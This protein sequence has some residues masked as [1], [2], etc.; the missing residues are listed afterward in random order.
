MKKHHYRIFYSQQESNDFACNDQIE[1]LIRDNYIDLKIAHLFPARDLFKEGIQ[2]IKGSKNFLDAFETVDCEKMDLM[3]PL[4]DIQFIKF[5]DTNEIVLNFIGKEYG[6]G[7]LTT[8]GTYDFTNKFL[9]EN[10]KMRKFARYCLENEFNDILYKNI[11][12]LMK[13]LPDQTK[14]YRF[15]KVNDKWFL[16]A[17]TSNKYNNYD[18][19][20]AI[21][22]TF[23]AVDNYAELN[24]LQLIVGD[25]Y[26][27]D[28]ELR[29]KIY[30]L[31]EYEI[32]NDVTVQFGFFTSNNELTEGT[33]SLEF[34]YVVRNKKEQTF[35]GLSNYIFN[36]THTVSIEKLEK[37][38]KLTKNI[39]DYKEE[40]LNYITQVYEEE[41][42][43]NQ[44]FNIFKT[45]T[46]AKYKVNAETRSK[47]EQIKEESIGNTMNLIELFNRLEDI[48]T[49]V[50]EKVYLE[51]IYHEVL[52]D[53]N[54]SIKQKINN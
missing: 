19:H 49:D 9:D 14:Q 46:S 39:N 45:I 38:F 5:D 48:T 26:L 22:T 15:L 51:R 8:V 23:V 37:Q 35:R 33:F 54:N 10:F 31:Q 36:L 41:L 18:N 42:S 52:V 25:S 40:I 3:E 7:G 24:N 6:A 16:R 21:Y 4:K 44:I 28:S 1:L 20:L 2:Y 53:I 17:L 50:N 43:E 30:E 29:L 34:S 27:T 12:D 11:K 13:K 32:N 47:V